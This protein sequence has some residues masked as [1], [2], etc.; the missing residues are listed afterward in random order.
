[1]QLPQVHQPSNIAFFRN[2]VLYQSAPLSLPAFGIASHIDICQFRHRSGL[3]GLIIHA[4]TESRERGLLLLPLAQQPL[5]AL[6][7]NL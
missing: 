3:Y 6:S 2:C 7:C 5:H 1:M 4:E